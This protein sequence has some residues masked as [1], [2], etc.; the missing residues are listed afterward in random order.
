VSRDP[1]DGA[2]E[3]LPLV[4]QPKRRAGVEPEQAVKLA[5]AWRAKASAVPDHVN[6]PKT[7]S[8]NP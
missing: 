6:P 1:C 4:A 7:R 5:I 3:Q 2:P 8:A